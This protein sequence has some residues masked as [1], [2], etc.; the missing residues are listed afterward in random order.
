MKKNSSPPLRKKRCPCVD[1]NKPKKQPFPSLISLSP[2][3]RRDELMYRRAIPPT[4]QRQ[5]SDCLSSNWTA[6]EEDGE[7]VCPLLRLLQALV[8]TQRRMELSLRPAVVCAGYTASLVTP[9]GEGPSL[10]GFERYARS[11]L[12][13]GGKV[14]DLCKGFF[15]T[16]AHVCVC[17]F[18]LFQLHFEKN[19]G[20]STNV[21]DI[22]K[23]YSKLMP[24]VRRI[25]LHF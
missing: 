20:E 11:H 2:P 23:L 22:T 9:G 13:A 17:A 6:E 10:G 16:L 25:L 12:R 5:I 3:R 18:L 24:L 14:R 1:H 21:G 7:G 8:R 15:S 4:V 19:V